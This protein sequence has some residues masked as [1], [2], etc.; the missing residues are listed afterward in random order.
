[1]E[2]VDEL[3]EYMQ[4]CYK[5]LLNVYS[6]IEQMLPEEVRSYR[7]Y[8]GIEAVCVYVFMNRNHPYVSRYPYTDRSRIP[9]LPPVF[10]LS[11]VLGWF[12][13]YVRR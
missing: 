4:L 9:W 8:Y 3:P 7:M 11:T 10:F 13:W 2:V 6:D 1:M 12:C 5:A